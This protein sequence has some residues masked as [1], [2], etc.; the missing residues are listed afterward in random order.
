[1]REIGF[2]NATSPCALMI[3]PTPLLI[4]PLSTRFQDKGESLLLPGAFPS[5]RLAVLDAP[6]K[7]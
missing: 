1:M 5:T 2:Y 7:P 4:S 6:T 3:H